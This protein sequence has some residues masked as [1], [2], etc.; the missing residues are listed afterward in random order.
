MKLFK[1]LN[2][3]KEA[4]FIKQPIFDPN[5]FFVTNL[6]ELA[7]FPPISADRMQSK[8]ANEIGEKLYSTMSTAINMVSYQLHAIPAVRKYFG[9]EFVHGFSTRG[10]KDGVYFENLDDNPESVQ[11]TKEMTKVAEVI[12][13]PFLEAQNFYILYRGTSFSVITYDE[14]SKMKHMKLCGRITWHD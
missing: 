4:P 3:P 10:E 7:Y 5:Q 11:Y 13:T 12:F 8:M 14:F 6:Y 1:F 9:D 2:Q